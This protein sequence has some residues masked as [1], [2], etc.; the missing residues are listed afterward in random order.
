M[1]DTA[2]V[3]PPTDAPVATGD[4]PDAA[5]VAM[6]GAVVVGALAL[7]GC[8]GGG[9]GGG[10]SS[11]VPPVNTITALTVK[12]T[13]PVPL[14]VNTVA[15]T[16]DGVIFG[17]GAARGGR[18]LQADPG[19]TGAPSTYAFT[20]SDGSSTSQLTVVINP[21][22]ADVIADAPGGVVTALNNTQATLRQLGFTPSWGE[23]AAV[24]HL[25]HS[26]MVDRVLGRL[27]ADPVVPYPAW[28]DER[29]LSWQQYNALSAADKDAYN[30][31]KWGR[32]NELRGWFFRQMV[33]SPDAFSERLLLFWH[34]V[35][36]SSLGTIEEPGLMLRQHRLYRQQM[37]GNFRD[38]VTAMS[39]D[40]A[41]CEYLD[42]ARNTIRN[43]SVPN[44]NF[45]REL[46]ELFTLGESQKYAYS[47]T[48]TYTDDDV[49]ALARFFTG[50]YIDRDN[51]WAYQFSLADHD[52]GAKTFFGATRAA[53]SDPA[54][55][56]ADGDWAIDQILARTISGRNLC[57][58]Y[59][60]HRLWEHFVG[61]PGSGDTAAI[62]ALGN[63]F[64]T[65]MGW[66]LQQLYKAFF[67][68]A[69]VASH[70]GAGDRIRAPVELWVAFYRV[71]GK[72]PTKGW[73][74]HVWTFNLLDQHLFTPP[75]VF[76][77]TG[78]ESWI[79]LKTVIDR[80]QYIGWLTWDAVLLNLFTPSQYPYGGTN[81]EKSTWLDGVASAEN[82]LAYLLLPSTPIDPPYATSGDWR[83]Y[84][85]NTRIAR[86]LTDPTFNLG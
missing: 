3:H 13:T 33:Q 58:F 2:L 19:P 84:H 5:S 18:A 56:A 74:D 65:T 59:I 44:E 57:G 26:Q 40:V 71:L 54:I 23:I 34:N 30:N 1:S 20:A 53:S 24:S 49:K 60:V 48:P 83:Y 79:N 10:S 66:D 77:W 11:A 7:S 29:I 38:F 27:G 9:G 39:R 36:T 78:N 21:A 15:G 73:T 80:R 6:A 72:A 75:T 14:T 22:P 82:S 61:T 70:R 50:Y 62:E 43:A 67:T 25:S 46:M 68:D 47:G 17:L 4:A 37:G 51:N 35:F 45:A 63:S 41:M 76:G 52:Q 16:A 81:I 8:G 69:A 85:A 32:H 28:I 55:A 12:A 86:L 64:A 31:R 42:S